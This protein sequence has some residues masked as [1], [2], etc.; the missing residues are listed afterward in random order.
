MK[1]ISILMATYNPNLSYLKLCLDSIESQTFKDFQL[2]LVDDGCSNC[3]LEEVLKSY[4]FEYKIIRNETNLGLPASLNKGLLYC[5]SE[6]IARMDDDD[7]MMQNR[8]ELEY[9]YAKKHDGMIFSRVRKI[10]SSGDEVCFD[11]VDADVEKYLK[12]SGN[13]LTHSTLFAKKSILVDCG[14]YNKVFTY[15]QDYELYMR[16]INNVKFHVMN[17]RLLYY[18]VPNSVSTTKK[19]M[20][21][22]FCY[23]AAVIYFLNNKSK[24]NLFYFLR[25]SLSM[26]KLFF[27][28]LIRS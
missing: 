2:I 1:T 7:I 15:A 17:E 18:R 4:S 5:D 12:K 22:L 20:S 10:D 13:C 24:K 9:D 3:N 11:D 16:L 23:G 8:L 27:M 6:Y 26:F 14:G 28:S 25:R 19:V 21:L